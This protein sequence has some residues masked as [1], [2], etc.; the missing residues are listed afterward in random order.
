MNIAGFPLQGLGQMASQ[1]TG[2]QSFQNVAQFATTAT[3][4][5]GLQGA[6]AGA[7]AG[8]VNLG[9]LDADGLNTMWN[10]FNGKPVDP[11]AVAKLVDDSN[12]LGDVS[13]QQGVAAGNNFI[14]G[15]IPDGL[16]N[17]AGALGVEM[18]SFGGFNPLSLF[19]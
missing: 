4:P 18:P 7:L 17:A 11:S 13:A 14:N 19:G 5:G 16:Q 2:N 1:I 10:L 6:V 9:P 15:N 8:N 3:Q 12:L